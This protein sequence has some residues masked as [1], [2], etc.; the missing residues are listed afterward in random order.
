MKELSEIK[1]V[2]K[3]KL[4]NLMDCPIKQISV[5]YEKG[6]AYI[7]IEVYDKNAYVM[8]EMADNNGGVYYAKQKVWVNTDFKDG[9]K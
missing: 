4:P 3:E 6:M 2:I 7:E 5:K 8:Y 1:S 9:G